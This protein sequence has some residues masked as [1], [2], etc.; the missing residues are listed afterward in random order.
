MV[1][2]VIVVSFAGDD[3]ALRN[4]MLLMR[5]VLTAKQ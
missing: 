4:Q 3:A 5:G 2:S 1:L